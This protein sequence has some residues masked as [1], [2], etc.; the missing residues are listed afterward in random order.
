L[1]MVLLTLRK[2][3][4]ELAKAKLTWLEGPRDGL[5][6]SRETNRGEWRVFINMGKRHLLSQWHG[7][8]VTSGREIKPDER[9]PPNGTLV[10]YRSKTPTESD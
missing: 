2:S 10:L 3:Y 6:F 5:C 1:T 9:I 4:P 7:K 8:C